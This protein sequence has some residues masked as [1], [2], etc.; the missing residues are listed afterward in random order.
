MGILHH[1]ASSCIILYHLASS[2]IIVRANKNGCPAVKH[3]S[4]S[5]DRHSHYRTVLK[6]E[7]IKE[8]LDFDVKADVTL[9]NRDGPSSLWEGEVKVKLEKE[10]REIQIPVQIF[11]KDDAKN[12]QKLFDWTIGSAAVGAIKYPMVFLGSK[13]KPQLK[14]LKPFI[15]DSHIVQIVCKD[16]K[17]HELMVNELENA[18]GEKN[19][20]F[21]YP[22]FGTPVVIV[23]VNRELYGSCISLISAKEVLSSYEEFRSHLSNNI[24]KHSWNEDFDEIAGS[25]EGEDGDKGSQCEGEEESTS[26]DHHL[27]NH[28]RMHTGEKPFQC[29]Y[30]C[31]QSSDLKST[32]AFLQGFFPINPSGRVILG[33]SPFGVTSDLKKH[34][35]MHTGEKP[36]T[37]TQCD[38]SCAQSGDLKKH[39]RT[40][41][42]EKPY[43][44]TQCDY[45]CAQSSTLKNHMRVHTGDK[46]Y[47]CTQCDYSCARSST[48]KQHMRV[49]TGEKPYTCTQCDYSCMQSHHLKIHM[50]VHTGEKP[51]QC[52]QCDYSCA[53][54]G[55][56]K[57]HM[58]IHTPHHPNLF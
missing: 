43:T 9:R 10:H 44:C 36:Y 28:M 16:L 39:M 13:S 53:Q 4:Y 35:R 14:H 49:H 57:R 48:L 40:H 23:T 46:P 55:D 47:Q 27:K 34:A 11:H 33:S 15:K 50:R 17:Q 51:Y 58:K 52:S 31:A 45:S 22:G 42:G 5:M 54:S 21:A 25:L 38:Y 3:F 29:D 8:E 20:F 19:F 30:S 41:T 26:N 37:C 1:L 32:V 56:I 7:T 6:I 18:N 12:G 24:V 2:C